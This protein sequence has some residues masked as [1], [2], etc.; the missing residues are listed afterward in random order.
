MVGGSSF[1]LIT[2]LLQLVL[3]R[4]DWTG[5]TRWIFRPTTI[6]AILA[7]PWPITWWKRWTSSI[8]LLAPQPPVQTFYFLL[9]LL[10]LLIMWNMTPNP[11]VTLLSML[12]VVRLHHNAWGMLLISPSLQVNKLVLPLRANRFFLFL[13]YISH[14]YSRQIHSTLLFP[15]TVPIVRTRKTGDPS[16]LRI[17]A[18]LVQPWPKTINL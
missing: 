8:T 4:R 12:S 7:F 2:A 16:P 3:A 1:T 6:W 9:Q 17:V 13:A 18:R 5:L 14:N 15:Q 10:C 11:W